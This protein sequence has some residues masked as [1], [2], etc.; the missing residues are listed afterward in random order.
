MPTHFAGGRAETRAL[1][2]FIKLT[3]CTNAVLARLAAQGTLGDLTPSQ[4]AVLEALYH[5][6]PLT[7]GDVSRKILKSV[8]NITALIDSLE[9]QG[10]ARRDRNPQ[11][12]RVVHVELTPR[13]RQRVAAL[14]P[15]HV[16]AL[17]EQFSVLSAAEQE[18]LARLCRKLGRGQE[19]AA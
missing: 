4:F 7:Q 12:R 16:A 10:L 13:G 1:D 2:A 11:D 6:G 19:P 3:R 17:V 18:T 14:L 15:R 9:Q 5:R 8:S